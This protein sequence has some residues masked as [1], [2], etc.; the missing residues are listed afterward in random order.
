MIPS[1]NTVIAIFYL[2]ILAHQKKHK[3]QKSCKKAKFIVGAEVGK[4]LHCD[5]MLNLL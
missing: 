2:F 1:I 4:V 3:N 5:E